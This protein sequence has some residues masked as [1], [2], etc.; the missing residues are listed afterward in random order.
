MNMKCKL[1]ADIHSFDRRETISL[2]Y[3]VMKGDE[4]RL[5][6]RPAR[7]GRARGERNDPQARGRRGDLAMNAKQ[8]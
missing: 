6:E 7:A 2:F 3:V 8:F 1:A 4:H 5:G